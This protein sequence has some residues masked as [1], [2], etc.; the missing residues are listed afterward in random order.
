MVRFILSKYRKLINRQIKKMAFQRYVNRGYVNGNDREDW[1]ISEKWLLFKIACKF[2]KRAWSFLN[3]PIIVAFVSFYILSILYGRYQMIDT[4]KKTV[5]YLPYAYEYSYHNSTNQPENRNKEILEE[6][7]IEINLNDEKNFWIGVINKNHKS[8]KDVY[9][10]LVFPN[11]I[12][13]KDWKE[14]GWIEYQ[15]NEQYSY[16]FSVSIHNGMGQNAMPLKLK[17][18][19]KKDYIVKY[20][21][22]GE[23]IQRKDKKFTIRVK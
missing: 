3:R 11:G 20:Y 8:L 14:Q 13:V 17:F 21:I 23:D 7:P 4:L 2:I 22:S 5:A 12:E 16:H 10:T 18:S 19:E 15:P 6:V 9:L 1:Y